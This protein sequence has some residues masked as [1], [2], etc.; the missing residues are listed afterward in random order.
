MPSTASELVAHLRTGRLSAVRAFVK[1]H[2]DAARAPG[3]I[4]EAGRLGWKAALALLHRQGADLNAVSRGYRPLHALLQEAPHAHRGTPTAARLAGLAWMLAHGADPDLAGGWPPA[5][6]LLV[7]AFVGEPT[8]VD[9]LRANG[10]ALNGFVAAALGDVRRVRTWLRKDPGAT[11]ARDGAGGLTALQ[12]CAASRMGTRDRQT[13]EAL[14]TVADL[15]LAHGADATART[16]GW[17]HELDAVYFAVHAGNRHIFQRLLERGADPTAA[18]PDVVWHDLDLAEL[19][20]RFGPRIDGATSGG[21]PLLNNL[22][23]W[24][25]VRAAM[26]MLDHGANPN[27]PD[28]NGWTAVHQAASRGNERILKALLDAGGRPEAPS[29]TGMLPI[30]IARASRKSKIVALLS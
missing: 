25:Q 27:L 29:A 30:D 21:K 13:Y 18:L 7:A 12:C 23:R 17:D 16:R 10:A 15:L 14:L 8:Y 6:A 24:G 20:L 11:S 28:L 19:L 4:C 22:I 26:W 1:A 5:R 3:A 9:V 2:P